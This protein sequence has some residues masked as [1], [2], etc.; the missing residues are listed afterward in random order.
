MLATVAVTS[1]V[2]N[3]KKRKRPAAK[4][5]PP[6][7]AQKKTLIPYGRPLKLPRLDEAPYVDVWIKIV[8][9]ALAEKRECCRKM[10]YFRHV[11]HELW[12]AT[13]KLRKN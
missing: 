10:R 5:W 1:T 13:V 7:S 4:D 12:E 2:K 9:L 8:S 6:T 3:K 11:H